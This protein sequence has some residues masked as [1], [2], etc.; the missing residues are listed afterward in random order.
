MSDWVSLDDEIFTEESYQDYLKQQK[1]RHNE[2]LRREDE[3]IFDALL[4]E[5]AD[6][7]KT[8]YGDEIVSA[9]QRY[10]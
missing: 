4:S 1:E 10:K 2:K 6:F 3:T 7:R 5:E 9:I 8:P